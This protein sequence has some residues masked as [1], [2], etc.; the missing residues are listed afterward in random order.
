MV[1][2]I[3]NLLDPD[4]D[5]NY[6]NVYSPSDDTYLIMDY[7]KKKIRRDYFDG[8]ELKNIR[9]VLDMGTGT[10]IIAIFLQLIKKLN[11]YFTAEIYASDILENAI[12]CAK[13]N[14]R[15]NNIENKLVFIQSDLFNSFPN[16]LKNSFEI[17]IFNP[18]YLPSFNNKIEESQKRLIDYS[19]DGGKMGFEVFLRFVSQAKNFLNLTQKCYI[20][21]ISSNRTELKKLIDLLKQQGYK[22]KILDKKHIFFEEIM[23]NRLELINY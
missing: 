10:G 4:I 12:K 22:N 6:E 2:I 5:N 20:Y 16:D 1:R 23:L 7:F 8:L 3:K 15:I 11:P 14:E 19:W 13:D 18:P 21:Y 9:K 17:I